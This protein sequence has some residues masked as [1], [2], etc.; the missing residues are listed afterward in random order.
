MFA[1]TVVSVAIAALLA[2]LSACAGYMVDSSVQYA[3]GYGYVV[4]VEYGDYSSSS[5]YPHEHFYYVFQTES[6]AHDFVWSMRNPQPNAS[7]R[8]VA[9]RRPRWREGTNQYDD[10]VRLAK[11]VPPR[12]GSDV[13]RTLDRVVPPVPTAPAPQ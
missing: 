1:R 10:I 8:E 5:P 6:E 4:K 13:N 12:G 7:P 11:P 2:L 9:A 3:P